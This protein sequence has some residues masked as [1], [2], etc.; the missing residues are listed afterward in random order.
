MLDVNFHFK[1][2]GFKRVAATV[3]PFDLTW[4]E[5]DMH[6]PASLADIRAAAPCPDLGIQG[7][8]MAGEMHL[9]AV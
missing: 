9:R 6:D 7:M 2:E 4:L 8:T 5:I 1:T 3:A